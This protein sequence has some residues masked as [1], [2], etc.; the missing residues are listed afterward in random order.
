MTGSGEIR[1]PA[2][3]MAD[4]DPSYGLNRSRGADDRGDGAGEAGRAP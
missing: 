4:H 3:R 2:G 1:D